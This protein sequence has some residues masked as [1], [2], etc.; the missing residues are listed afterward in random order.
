MVIAF[1]AGTGMK[2][3]DCTNLVPIYVNCNIPEIEDFPDA[4]ATADVAKEYSGRAG[5]AL[6]E[7]SVKPII[8]L[9]CSRHI[10]ARNAIARLMLQSRFPLFEENGRLCC[11]NKGTTDELRLAFRTLENRLGAGQPDGPRGAVVLSLETAGCP[12]DYSFASLWAI[13]PARTH[14]AS[15]RRLVAVLTVTPKG[16]KYSMDPALVSSMFGLTPAEAR[17]AA[18]LV[19]GTELHGIADTQRLSIETVRAQLKSV[20]NKTNTHRQTDLVSLFLRLTPY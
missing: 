14:G 3:R 13:P 15:G 10:I 9:D 2:G 4:I 8:L 17:L 19:A 12:T 20:F 11:A 16:T 1:V 5:Q 18:L 7:A 6:I